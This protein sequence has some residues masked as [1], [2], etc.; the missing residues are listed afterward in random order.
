MAW[1]S[2][3]KTQLHLGFIGGCEISP[4]NA[5][6]MIEPAKDCGASQLP[7]LLY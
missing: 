1:K 5:A 6:P 4:L 7:H 3:G 2:V